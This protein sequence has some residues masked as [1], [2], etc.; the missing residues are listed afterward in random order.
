MSGIAVSLMAPQVTAK[1]LRGMLFPAGDVLPHVVDI[2]TILPLGSRRD[3]EPGKPFVTVYLGVQFS[4]RMLEVINGRGERQRFVVFWQQ[5]GSGAPASMTTL[6]LNKA[7]EAL[8]PGCGFRGDMLLMKVGK[9][10]MYVHLDGHE[11]K[12]LASEALRR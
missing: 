4:E 8:V 3:T 5:P 6:R 12:N 7:A 11:Q 10:G 9:R 1:F 2:S